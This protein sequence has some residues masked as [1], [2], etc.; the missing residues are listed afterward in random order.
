MFIAIIGISSAMQPI[1]AF[2]FG[3]RNF[4]RVKNTVKASIKTVTIISLIFGVFIMYFAPKMI[5]LFLTDAKLL[6]RLLRPL[7]YVYSYFL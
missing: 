3:A 2:N 6:L 1:V 5:G 4:D 7:E